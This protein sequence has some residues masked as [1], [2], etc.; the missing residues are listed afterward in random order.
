[1]SK[2]DGFPKPVIGTLANRVGVRC[3]NPGCRKSTAGPREDNTKSVNIGVA[4]HITAAADG[5]PRYNA[6][7]S[8]EERGSIENGIWL[9]QNCAKLIDNDPN[10]YTTEVLQSWKARAE[11]A[12]REELEG[13]PPDSDTRATA[14]L[15]LEW[16]KLKIR[17]ERHEY[18]LDVS[19]HNVGTSVLKDYH[20]DIL[21]PSSVL[22]DSSGKVENRSDTNETLI[23]EAWR[24]A[25]DDIFP[26]DRHVV[27]KIPYFMDYQLFKNRGDLF[28]RLVRATLYQGGLLRVV[29]E[30]RFGELQ[31]F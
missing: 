12:A 20:I 18:M 3:S 1:M 27:V 22:L 7:L 21:V 2:R 28:D 26:G 5:G 6:S 19:I 24:S 17:S 10:R 15:I 29:I 30:R 8:V 16:R 9:C 31:F 25:E 23:R 11:E 14:D 4:A 13:I